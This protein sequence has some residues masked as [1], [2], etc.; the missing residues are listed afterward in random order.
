MMSLRQSGPEHVSKA[1]IS[2]C[3]SI[4]SSIFDK[5]NERNIRFTCS[6]LHKTRSNI[7]A[8]KLAQNQNDGILY[9]QMF[10]PHLLE[11]HSP[12]ATQ[13]LLQQSTFRTSPCCLKEQLPESAAAVVCACVQSACAAS[14]LHPHGQSARS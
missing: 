5:K 2:A 7:V 9:L 10:L 11:D 4:S 1:S 12:L 13:I 8:H 6:F 3:P 14:M